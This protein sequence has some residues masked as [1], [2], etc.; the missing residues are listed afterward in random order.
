[1]IG[2]AR[3]YARERPELV[4]LLAFALTALTLLIIFYLGSEVM[5]G[6]TKAF[7]I[8]VLTRLR[9]ATEGDAPWKTA[10]RAAMLDLTALGDNATLVIVVAMVSGFLM[11]ARQRQ[12]ALLLVAASATGGLLTTALKLLFD[13]PRPDVVAH[14]ASFGT[15]SFPSGHA[16]NSAV[17]YLTLAG[18]VALAVPTLRL[19]VYIL[20]CAVALTSAIGLSR[21]YLGVHWTTDVVAGWIAGS[22]WAVLWWSIAWWFRARKAYS[23]K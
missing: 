3:A 5:E 4:V 22:G 9:H 10:L 16:M 2:R 1:M 7:D 19:R 13:R 23:P 15:A 21:L 14:L 8:A 11:L 17:I 20:C 12:L 6:D 18:L